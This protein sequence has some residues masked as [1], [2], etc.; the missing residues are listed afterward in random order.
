MQPS[1]RLKRPFWNQA[2]T[3]FLITPA[4]GIALMT[5]VVPKNHGKRKNAAAKYQT[6]MN[7]FD[8]RR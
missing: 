6:E 5:S 7:G 3:T 8:C 4:S 1:Q 2:L